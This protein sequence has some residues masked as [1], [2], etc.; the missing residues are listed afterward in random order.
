M[1]V[2]SFFLMVIV[3]L[4]DLKL[5]TRKKA[6]FQS[7]SILGSA[8]VF[9]RSRQKEERGKARPEEDVDRG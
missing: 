3:S 8:V 5:A 6:L 4:L 7:K 9:Q 1:I 2:N